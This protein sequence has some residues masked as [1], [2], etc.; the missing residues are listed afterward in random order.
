MSKIVNEKTAEAF[1]RRTGMQVVS[2]RLGNVLVPETYAKV[3]ARF[4]HPEDRLRI[5][6]SYIDARDAAAACRLAIEK[7]GLGAVALNLAAED[8][9]SNIPTKELVERYLPGVKDIRAPLEGRVSLLNSAKARQL[10]GWEA[11]YKI[12][13]Q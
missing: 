10:L 8:S 13:E 9:S 11:Q 3:K 4:D 12:M 6:W 7:E 5:L 2:F 1:N